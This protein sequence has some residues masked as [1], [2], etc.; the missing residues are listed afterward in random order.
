MKREVSLFK[1]RRIYG[2]AAKLLK[3][4]RALGMTD[5]EIREHFQKIKSERDAKKA[6]A[7]PPVESGDAK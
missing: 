1:D 4:L 7:I 5:A 2:N 3:A 6:E